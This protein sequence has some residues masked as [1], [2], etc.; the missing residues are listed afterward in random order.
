MERRRIKG[1]NNELIKFKEDNSSRRGFVWE[2]IPQREHELYPP[3]ASSLTGKQRK[4]TFY[5][6]LAA[7]KS[8]LSGC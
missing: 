1:N 6:K 4:N 8:I 7:M 2:G 3:L 5:R